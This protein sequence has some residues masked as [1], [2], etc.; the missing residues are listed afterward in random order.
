RAVEKRR[1]D[2]EASLGRE[3]ERPVRC[4]RRRDHSTGSGIDLDDAV[5]VAARHEGKT[6]VEGDVLWSRAHSDAE[7]RARGPRIER[8]HRIAGTRGDPDAASVGAEGQIVCD[9]AR[10]EAPN[11]AWTVGT[12]EVDDRD[13]ARMLTERDP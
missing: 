9:E 6:P 13:L 3:V 11:Q 1:G 5:A 10:R 4:R 2:D 12:G 7:D 8:V